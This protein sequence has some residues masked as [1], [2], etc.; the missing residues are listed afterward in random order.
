MF[1]FVAH[2]DLDADFASE[3]ALKLRE[4]G[5]E[6]FTGEQIYRG[7]TLMSFSKQDIAKALRAA[8]VLV[9]FGLNSLWHKYV[10]A[11]VAFF[12]GHTTHDR[13][14]LV[15]THDLD[16]RT[17]AYLLGRR[18]VYFDGDRAKAIDAVLNHV[19]SIGISH[20]RAAD[21]IFLSYFALG[22]DREGEPVQRSLV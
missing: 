17:P 18:L 5:H 22:V 10:T 19:A 7:F 15:T 4:A 21:Q 12:S 11:E 2:T 20:R 8:D 9:A 3:T 16:D 1:V 13:T 6:A 14:I